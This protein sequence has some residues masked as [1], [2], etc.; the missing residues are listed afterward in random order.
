[1]LSHA[2]HRVSAAPIRLLLAAALVFTLLGSLPGDA[3]SS[4]AAVATGTVTGASGAA[5][6]GVAVDLYAW[7]SDAVLAA[8][9]P[10]GAVP[11]TLLATATTNN[12]GKYTLRV[13]V[14]G[15]KAAAVEPG[16]ANLEI[17]SPV[18]LWFLPYQTN[19]LPARPAAPVTVNLGRKSPPSCGISN[20]RRPYNF[21]GFML[22]RQMAPAWAVVAEGYIIR[23][24]QTSG[25]Y[26]SFTVGSN[27]SQAPELGL[28]I[29]GY[30]FDAGYE[31][32]GSG[33]SSAPRGEGFAK[34][35]E[36]A[37]FRTE[38]STGLFRGICFGPANDASVPYVHQ[39]G[40]CPRKFLNHG[41]VF[42]VHKCLWMVRSTG[43]FG[44]ATTVHPR[45][46]PRTPAGNCAP[47]VK[48]SGLGDIRTAV[49][50]SSGFDL[51][52]ALGIKGVNLKTSF[53]GS[54]QTSA[55]ANDVME[56]HFGHA[57]FLC[58]TNGSNAKATTL[59]QRGNKP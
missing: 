8:M 29:S 44:G 46:A 14:A 40:R 20:D 24:K 3:A 10:G 43:W 57:G 33:A 6:P 48:G 12:A 11:T 17:F 49:H 52:A 58:G 54:V 9:R 56:F 50:S 22:E 27:P 38:F 53:N 59:V 31:G 51:G 45:L 37:W 16:Y 32:A 23:Q 55:D 35:F 5:L 13:P 21:T 2:L 15:L 4:F 25:D 36:S 41:L 19:A 18:G 7:P 1:M 28:G 26:V 42:Y 39:H 47:Y 30:G 34:S